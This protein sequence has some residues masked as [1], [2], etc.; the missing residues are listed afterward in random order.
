[1]RHDDAQNP[2]FVEAVRRAG[3]TVEALSPRTLESF[4]TDGMVSGERRDPAGGGGGG[5]GCRV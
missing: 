1:M 2:V 4:R 5:G 3:A